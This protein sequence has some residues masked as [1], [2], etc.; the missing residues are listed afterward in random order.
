M[1]VEGYVAPAAVGWP[2]MLPLMLRKTPFGPKPHAVRTPVGSVS[3]TASGCDVG[4]ANCEC[5][6]IVGSIQVDQVR[7][8][9]AAVWKR[10]D[11]V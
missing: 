1:V 3:L 7:G 6:Q 9:S 8:K 2:V 4:A 5:G 11:D 10:D